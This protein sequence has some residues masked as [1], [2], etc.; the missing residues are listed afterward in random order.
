MER[1]KHPHVGT[2]SL[3]GRGL[4]TLVLIASPELA[5]AEADCMARVLADVPALEAPEE[6]KS[7]RSGTFGPIT[8]IKVDKSSGKMFY[9]SGT[10][11]CYDSNAFRITT[12]C[13]LKLVEGR[14]F[15][16][17]FAHYF[18]YSAR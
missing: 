4:A 5:R 1:H 3:V 2:A 16:R 10:S 18:T 17:F 9:C 6:V 8:E 13:R 11:Y 7:R 15:T 14:G 12:P